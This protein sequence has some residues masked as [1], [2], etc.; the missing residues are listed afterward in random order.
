MN[1]YKKKVENFGKNI[2]EME[3]NFENIIIDLKKEINNL[4]ISFKNKMKEYIKLLKISTILFIIYCKHLNSNQLTYEII[5]NLKNLSDFNDLN[6]NLIKDKTNIFLKLNEFS[7]TKKEFNV[8]HST[9]KLK[10]KN[11]FQKQ[12][13]IT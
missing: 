10:N 5:Q 11:Q 7:K 1:E 3:K 4:K 8:L 2:L 6:N 13:V 9:K 12:I